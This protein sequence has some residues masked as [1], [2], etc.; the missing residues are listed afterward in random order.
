MYYKIY[1]YVYINLE[2]EQSYERIL[3]LS[4]VNGPLVIVI[5]PI[6]ICWKIRTIGWNMLEHIEI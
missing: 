1:K 3:L 5:R 2:S 4:M 6:A